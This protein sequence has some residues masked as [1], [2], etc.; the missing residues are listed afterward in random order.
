MRCPEPFAE[1]IELLL[2]NEPLRRALGR[3]AVE[4]M[5]SYSWS[6]VSARLCKLYG[7]LLEEA[8]VT[9]VAGD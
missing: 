2:R 9:S 7:E 8:A 3:A 5:R 6:A 1:K 4:H